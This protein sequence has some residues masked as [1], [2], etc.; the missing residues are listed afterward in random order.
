LYRVSEL[1][2][3]LT[4]LTLA[5][6]RA[7]TPHIRV[8]SQTRWKSHKHITTKSFTGAFGAYLSLLVVVVV[9]VVVIV[10][11]VAVVQKREVFDVTVRDVLAAGRYRGS[12][13]RLRAAAKLRAHAGVEGGERRRCL[14]PQRHCA[15]KHARARA[16][17][18]THARTHTHTHTHTQ[19]HCM[20]GF[21]YH[22]AG[23]HTNIIGC[24][25]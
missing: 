25:F 24:I 8:L 17:T 13:A 6:E 21:Y 20:G 2:S 16:C 15:H 23:Y 10:A 11:V 9:V 14:Q 22:V 1:A 18:R 4:R 7:V 19:L 3:E 5:A 12:C